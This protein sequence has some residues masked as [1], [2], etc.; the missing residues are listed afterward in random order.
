MLVGYA[1]V[2]TND[3]ETD[4]QVDALRAA[5]VTTIYFEKS[6]SVG[7]RPQLQQ[8]LA[9]MKPGDVLVVWKTDRLSRG[10]QDLLSLLDGLKASGCRFRSLT[11]PIDT[12]SPLGEFM[13]QI[14]GSVAQLERA[15]IR[16]RVLAGQVAAISRGGK[17]GRPAVLSVSE[18]AEVVRRYRQG[19]VTMKEL[20][21]QFGVGRWVIERIVFVA[22]NPGHPRYAARRPVL[23]P[24]LD[25]TQ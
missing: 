1:R 24:L 13:L 19:D 8:A 20:A 4:L 10:L 5:G 7:A 22:E 21:R 23:G 17:H 12:T 18:Q 11:E 6:S 16:Q 14:L 2:S 3:Q 25:A 9:S 15:M